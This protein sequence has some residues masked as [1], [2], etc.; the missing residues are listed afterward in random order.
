MAAIQF[1]AR[2]GGWSYP[3]LVTLEKGRVAME[4]ARINCSHCVTC[5][6]RM[7]YVQSR[8]RGE[9]ETIYAGGGVL[10]QLDYPKGRDRNLISIT[11]FLSEKFGLQIHPLQ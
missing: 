1:R 8:L 4:V 3:R 9:G 11:Q 5:R 7:N 6:G 2:V 10:I